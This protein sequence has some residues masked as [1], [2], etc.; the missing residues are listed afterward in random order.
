MFHL[1]KMLILHDVNAINIYI[2]TCCSTL[3]WILQVAFC[4]RGAALLVPLII[5]PLPG[6]CASCVLWEGDYSSSSSPCCSALPANVA[7]VIWQRGTAPVVLLVAV[8]VAS[9]SRRMPNCSLRGGLPLEFPPAALLSR[10]NVPNCKIS[11]GVCSCVLGD[12]LP[13]LALNAWINSCSSSSLSI[14]YWIC[15]ENPLQ[16]SVSCTHVSETILWAYY[17][18]RMVQSVE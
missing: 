18:T 4:E 6:E 5:V 15:S 8:V 10:S 14:F 11:A 12:L 2:I 1:N 13:L 7:I 3:S 9:P 17:W 16:N